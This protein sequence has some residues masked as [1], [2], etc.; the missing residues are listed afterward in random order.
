[1]INLAVFGDPV[2]HSLSPLIHQQF[3]EHVGLAIEYRPIQASTDNFQRKLDA[4]QLHGG[5]GANLTLPH[6]QAGMTV[7]ADL[8]MR[9]VAANAV[10][11]LLLRPNGWYGDN[12]DGLGLVWDL[13]RLQVSL[14]NQHIL[15]IGAGGAA[16]GIIPILLEQNPAS[17]TIANRTEARAQQL[18]TQ[19]EKSPVFACSLNDVSASKHIG[20]II[21]ASAA[22]HQNST[23]NLSSFDTRSQPFCYDLS[24]GQAAQPFLQWASDHRYPAIGG[25]GMLVGQAAEA[26]HLWTTCTINSTVREKILNQLQSL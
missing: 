15:I 18:A 11:T 17:I 1:M 16:Q 22:G 26:F 23:F 24:Y 19:F 3:A 20:L 21:H 4:F 13:Q 5:V 8:S 10:N 25:L 7:C 14:T 12:T 2:A 9:A 6:K